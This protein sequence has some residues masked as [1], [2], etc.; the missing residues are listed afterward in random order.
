[1]TNL[2]Q[3]WISSNSLPIEP[4]KEKMDNLKEMYSDCNYQLYTNDNI[5]EFLIDNFSSDILLAY[6]MCRSY[7]FKSD[8]VRYCL[9]Y[10][11]GGYYFDVSICPNFRLECDYDAYALKG[12]PE[13]IDG[14][15]ANMLDN[16][17]MFFKEPGNKF[18]KA[19]IDKTVYNIL[20]HRYGNHALDITG[21]MMLYKLDHKEIHLF[22]CSYVEGKKVICIDDEVWLEYPKGFSKLNNEQSKI[23][24]TNSYE[25]MWYD[26]SIFNNVPID[27]KVSII[28]PTYN[29]AEYIC[30]AIDSALNQTYNNIEVIVV[31]DGST[32]NTKE[33]VTKKYKDKVTYIHQL[34]QGV[35]SARNNGITKSTGT[36]ILTLDADDWIDPQYIEHALKKIQNKVSLITS[37]AHF[38]DLNLSSLGRTYPEGSIDLAKTKLHRLVKENYVVTT[39]L[40]SKY[41]WHLIGG[42]DT[43]INRAEDWEF[44][45]NMVKNGAN[46]LY[47]EGDKPYLKYRTHQNSK[48]HKLKDQLNNT[49]F[50]MNR[51]HNIKRILD[52]SDLYINLLGREVDHTGL[53]NYFY[54]NLN[55]KEIK[56]DLLNSTEYKIKRKK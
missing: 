36:W 51:K 4:I 39:S 56:T 42:Y 5:V 30:D 55:I 44:W 31:D 54:S 48:S 37:R 15:T 26:R 9:L 45:I 49:I 10:T 14:K 50:Y 34:N 41:M 1:M 32:D 21:P 28:I 53:M 17:V 27:T 25:L 7:A 18:L 43:N 12:T 46:V 19:A 23:T 40:F 33:I 16:G 20:H 24:G 38:V 29:Y 52:I 13:H 35:S 3:I 2:F 11:Y 22:P 8:L 6:N 47:L